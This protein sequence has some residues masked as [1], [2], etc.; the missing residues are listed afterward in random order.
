MHLLERVE[1]PRLRHAGR[2]GISFKDRLRVLVMWTA[3]RAANYRSWRDGPRVTLDKL[4]QGGVNLVLSVLL[5]PLDEMDLGQ[6]Y[7]APPLPHYYP[8]LLEQLKRVELDLAEQDP[9]G[10]RHVIVRSVDDL[11]DRN[12]VAVV[13]CVEGGFHLGTTPEEVATHVAELAGRGV[14]YITLAHLFWRGIAANAPALPFLSDPWYDRLFPQP[15]NKGLTDLGRAAVEAMYRHKVL[16]DLSHMRG[17]AIT[18]ALGMLDEL[19]PEHRFPVVA[20]HAGVRFPASAQH[21]QLAEGTVLQIADRGGVIGL[22]L[23]EHQ[24]GDGLRK[25]PTRR[26]RDSVDV[27]CRHIDRIEEISGPGH[28]ALGTDLDGFIKPT[29][30]G[31]ETAADLAKLRDP[32]LERY[33]DEAKVDAFLYGNARRVIEQVLA[34]RAGGARGDGAR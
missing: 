24:L 11:R 27:I 9:G 30:S 5:V 15:Q 20:T 21:Y 18:E 23:A 10:T 26:L 25:R 6:P 33:R 16:I 3:N 28:V 1:K 13:H 14:M 29:M 19:D 4:E 17:D 22:I 34:A 31:L 12:R 8:D 32:L 2:R 7:G